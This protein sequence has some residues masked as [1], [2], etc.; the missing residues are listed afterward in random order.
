[1]T[2]LLRLINRLTCLHDVYIIDP[3]NSNWTRCAVCGKT[4]RI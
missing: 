3:D 2:W 4:K 1:M